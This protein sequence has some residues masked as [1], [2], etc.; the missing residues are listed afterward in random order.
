MTY[1]VFLIERG[2]DGVAIVTMNRPHKLNAMHRL[3]FEELLAVMAELTAD[4][5]VRACVLTGAGRAFSAGGD[6]ETFPAL[7]DVAAAR[8]HVRLVFDAFHAVERASIPVI[9]AVNGI[10]HGGGTEI[11]L[12]CDY[13]IASA[14]HASFA[15]REAGHGL[16][17]GFGLTRGAQKLGNPTIFR[18]AGTAEVIDA[19]R[20]YD[21]GLA[22]E[23][24]P[25]AQL[26]DRALELARAFAVNPPTAVDAIKR[27]LN[28]Y[29]DQ[30]LNEAVETTA[31]LFGTTDSQERVQTFLSQRSS[32]S[33]PA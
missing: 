32:A 27:F 19:R 13:V 1:E 3:F 7:A 28:R 14:E 9:A 23:V 22:Q 5:S 31:L 21:I 8:K 20:A 6:I 24:V 12:A 16:M 18:L 33:R 2:D 29:T 15:L 25:H 11:S 10:A 30:G 4:D 17:P 26:I